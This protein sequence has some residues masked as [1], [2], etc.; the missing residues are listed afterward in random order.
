MQNGYRLSK[1][2][3]I[4]HSVVLVL[5]FGDLVIVGNYHSFEIL[6]TRKLMVLFKEIRT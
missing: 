4:G 5:D 1:L 3:H 2:F 6:Q